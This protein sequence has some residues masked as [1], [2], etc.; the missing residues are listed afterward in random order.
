MDDV[1]DFVCFF[2]FNQ[3]TADEMRISDWS[4][5]VC[6]SDLHQRH[7]RSARLPGF[8]GGEDARLRVERV[9]DRLDQ[10][11]VDSALQQRV[12][13]LAVDV[14][15]FVEPDRAKARVVDVRGQ[16]Q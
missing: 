7:L 13:L 4:S 10:D 3:K 16:G 6:S 8:Y 9:E 2:F 15:Q 5:D 1:G 11:E 14:L 12:D